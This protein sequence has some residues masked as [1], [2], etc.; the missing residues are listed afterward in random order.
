ML[1]KLQALHVSD[2]PSV[3]WG[4]ASTFDAYGPDND[5]RK[6]STWVSLTLHQCVSCTDK[7]FFEVTCMACK[8]LSR[9]CVGESGPCHGGG[10]Q[11]AEVLLVLEDGGT[12]L[13][14]CQC[15]AEFC[16]VCGLRSRTCICDQWNEP[17]LYA[18]GAELHEQQWGPNVDEG[19]R[20]RLI[21]R[22]MENILETRDCN[23]ESWLY[24]R[25]SRQCDECREDLPDR[26]SLPG[27]AVPVP[28]L[29]TL[30]I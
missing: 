19:Q 14:L 24:R 20:D 12:G 27:S 11:L 26:L 8:G 9:G 28:G 15:G 13:W 25:G 6:S 29:Q 3:P 4:Y 17:Q 7:F 23:H 10:E 2:D 30:Q 22:E 21:R 16:Y 18:R 1:D 5:A